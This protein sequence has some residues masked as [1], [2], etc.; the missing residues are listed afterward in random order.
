MNFLGAIG[1]VM[2]GSGLEELMGQLYGPNTLDHVM[3]GKAFA[4]A[5]RG[6]IIIHDALV[7]LL[8][9]CVVDDNYDYTSGPVVLES[10]KD[11]GFSVANGSDIADVIKELYCST[12]NEKVTVTDYSILECECLQE[13]NFALQKLK[14]CFAEQSRTSR[15]WVQYME[16]VDLLKLFI[17]AERTSDWTLHLM[18]CYRMLALFAAAGHYKLC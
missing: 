7:Q 10:D 15:L 8:L 11:L 13:I 5:I 16:H 17:V 14:H 4:R 1:Y 18:T 6:H 2:K 12:W 3:S 9:K